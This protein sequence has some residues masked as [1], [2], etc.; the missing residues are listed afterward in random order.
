MLS[1]WQE[2]EGENALFGES[3]YLLWQVLVTKEVHLALRHDLP[4]HVLHS[5]RSRHTRH[6]YHTCTGPTNTPLHASAGISHASLIHDV[7]RLDH[8]LEVWKSGFG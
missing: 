8:T 4:A 6:K 3:L 7:I 5:N 1:T 2:G